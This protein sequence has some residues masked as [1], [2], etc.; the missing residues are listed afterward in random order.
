[1]HVRERDT[2]SPDLY[3]AVDGGLRPLE[4]RLEGELLHG[5]EELAVPPLVG[6]PP[7]VG[8]D[9]ARVDAVDGDAGAGALQAPRQLLGVQHVGQ[10]GLRVGVV[11]IVRLLPVQVVPV[12]PPDFVGQTRD[13]HDPVRIKIE[14]KEF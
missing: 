10:L 8:G 11:G 1:M 2:P 3:A 12:H 9:D 6:V 7:Q 5:P 14:K 4:R 13:D